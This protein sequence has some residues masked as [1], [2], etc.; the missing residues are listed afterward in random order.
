M[1]TE[2]KLAFC[3]CKRLFELTFYYSQLIICFYK[4][5]SFS[6][7]IERCK[8]MQ[9]ILEKR[10]AKHWRHRRHRRHGKH[11][12]ETET[13]DIVMD[14]MQTAIVPI[15]PGIVPSAHFSHSNCLTNQKCT[16][17]SLIHS[18]STP[19]HPRHRQHIL[20]QPLHSHKS[21]VS[22]SIARPSVGK[23]CSSKRSD[24]SANQKSTTDGEVGLSWA[25]AEPKLCLNYT[26]AE[27][28]KVMR[29]YPLLAISDQNKD[30]H[31]LW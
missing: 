14:R 19:S 25:G 8:W 5:Y 4:C 23:V 22:D 13:E 27:P 28:T 12:T 24:A 10:I 16:F 15:V 30:R 3:W 26:G 21:L 17:H 2:L 29:L 1:R 20:C 6:E 31:R 7:R 9:I 11:T 18:I